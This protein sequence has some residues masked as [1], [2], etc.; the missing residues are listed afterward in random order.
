MKIIYCETPE[1]LASLYIQQLDSEKK[2]VE[3]HIDSID[4]ILDDSL[5][6]ETSISSSGEDGIF[7]WNGSLKDWMDAL[8]TETKKSCY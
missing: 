4:V 3:I 6:I 1:I 2:T 7:K 5:S 8:I